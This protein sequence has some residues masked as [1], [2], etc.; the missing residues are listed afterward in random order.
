MRSYITTLMLVATL[1]LISCGGGNDVTSSGATAVSAAA[2][3]TTN[4]ATT[5]ASTPT[6]PKINGQVDER[7]GVAPVAAQATIWT[8]YSNGGC[9][10]NATFG[11]FWGPPLT[12]A[13][14][15]TCIYV[16]DITTTAAG[17]SALGGSWQWSTLVGTNTPAAIC[18]AGSGG[19][20]QGI[21]Q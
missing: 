15:N 16:L 1:G 19:I 10:N 11:G 12:Q 8:P 14:Y 6:E 20:P 17:C 5:T 4:D 3:V 9:L 7:T 18:L 13:Q 2:P 21:Q